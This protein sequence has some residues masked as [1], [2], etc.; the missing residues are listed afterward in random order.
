MD[1]GVCGTVSYFQTTKAFNDFWLV[2]STPLKNISQLGLL[3]PIYEKT[4][5]KPPT[6]LMPLRSASVDRT[7]A[8]AWKP[9]LT[10]FHG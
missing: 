3:S 10:S 8:R 1:F 4:C 2:V 5:S 7:M 6:R 9:T